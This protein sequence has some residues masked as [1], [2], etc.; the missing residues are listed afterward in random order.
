MKKLPL[1]KK[2]KKKLIYFFLRINSHLS[3]L[4]KMAISYFSFCPPSLLLVHT[5][6][7]LDFCVKKEK[8]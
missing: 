2:I 3:Y 4:T 6:D 1:K 5:L 8:V 7:T